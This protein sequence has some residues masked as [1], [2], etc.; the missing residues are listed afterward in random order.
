AILLRLFLFRLLHGWRRFR[1]DRIGAAS[2]FCYGWL[3]GGRCE[4][5]IVAVGSRLWSACV[6]IRRRRSIAAARQQAREPHHRIDPTSGDHLP[7]LVENSIGLLAYPKAPAP[8]FKVSTEAHQRSRREKKGP[9]DAV[10]GLGVELL[11][12]CQHDVADVDDFV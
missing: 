2:G 1:D 4:R 9:A 7:L 8:D 5:G 3:L 12:Q 11:H 10:G 6:I